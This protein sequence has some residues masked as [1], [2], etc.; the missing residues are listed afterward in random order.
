MQNLG[1]DLHRHSKTRREDLGGGRRQRRRLKWDA[2]HHPDN[3]RQIWAKFNDKYV[4]KY[5]NTL[6]TSLKIIFKMGTEDIFRMALL[7]CD[8]K[9]WWSSCRKMTMQVFETPSHR[10]TA[11][12][13]QVDGYLGEWLNIVSK[14]R[15]GVVQLLLPNWNMVFQREERNPKNQEVNKT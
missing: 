1:K 4:W 15:A 10:G 9:S 2:P 6:Y 8:V 11:Q 14:I 5:Q 12:Q 3:R 13:G 7:K